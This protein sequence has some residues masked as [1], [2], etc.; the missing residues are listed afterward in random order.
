MY[1][2]RPRGRIFAVLAVLTFVSGCLSTGESPTGVV[3][4]IELASKGEEQISIETLEESWRDY[5]VYYVGVHV[6]NASALLFDPID[7]DKTLAETR[8]PWEE[9]AQ[10][11]VDI[12]KNKDANTE[13]EISRVINAIKGQKHAQFYPRLYRIIGPDD[14]LYGYLYTAWNRAL[15]RSGNGTFSVLV[16]PVPPAMEYVR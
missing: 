8:K 9:G 6:G 2:K 7:D 13:I 14:S 5:K 12:R 11:W 10:R 16:K 15:V 3:G 4:T 1:K